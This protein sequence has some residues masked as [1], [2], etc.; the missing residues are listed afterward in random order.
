MKP[1][2]QK[3]SKII[4]KR[5]M[6]YQNDALGVNIQDN[7]LRRSQKVK[8]LRKEVKKVKFRSRKK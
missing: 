8:N 4:G 2:F 6:V 5:P 1:D 3:I 7:L